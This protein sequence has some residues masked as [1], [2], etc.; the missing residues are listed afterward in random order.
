MV[1]LQF[2]IFIGTTRIHFPYKMELLDV[3]TANNQWRETAKLFLIEREHTSLD[4][5]KFG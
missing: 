3:I 2:L 4:V 1:L 5:M